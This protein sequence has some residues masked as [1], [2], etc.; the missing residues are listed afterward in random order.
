MDCLHIKGIGWSLLERRRGMSDISLPNIYFTVKYLFLFLSL[1]DP[2]GRNP[3]HDSPE[4]APLLQGQKWL[5]R[6]QLH[7]FHSQLRKCQH[8]WWR[9]WRGVSRT[10][11][12][13]VFGDLVPHLGSLE[14]KEGIF[15]LLQPVI[16]CFY[17]RK[18]V[19]ARAR[20]RDLQLTWLLEKG[21][22]KLRGFKEIIWLGNLAE[23]R[24]VQ[25]QPG[26]GAREFGNQ[27]SRQYVLY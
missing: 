19:T 21:K 18:R 9:E 25:V 13:N 8:R 1:Q 17:Y 24:E 16:I 6:L 7:L 23:G 5:H 15:L 2:P 12:T 4:K 11:G 26:N 20:L 3:A 27:I 10:T 14:R 22:K